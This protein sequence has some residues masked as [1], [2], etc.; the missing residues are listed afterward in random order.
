M[1]KIFLVVLI[2]IC[3]SA[4]AQTWE[5]WFQQKETQKKYLLQQIAALEVYYD[6]AK[7]G[8]DVASKGLGIIQQIKNGDFD[9]HQEFFNSLRRVN[10]AIANWSRVG[11]I[12]N[13]QINIVKRVKESNDFLKQSSEFTK[14]ERDYFFGVLKKIAEESVADIDE[15]I[16]I[17]T[18]DGL[19]MKDDERIKRIEMLYGGMGGRLEALLAFQ[20]E[21]KL[22][23]MRRMQEKKGIEI[24]NRLNK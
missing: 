11:E 5:E 16:V 23:E 20:S 2:L 1:M 3:N 10:P 8:Y 15:L 7:K 14:Q 12:I 9:L 21:I 24:S 22:L 19:V 4:N 18:A 6:Y 13:L 17:I